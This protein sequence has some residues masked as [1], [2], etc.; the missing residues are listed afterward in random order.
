MLECKETSV[1]D[2][3]QQTKSCC[4][5]NKLIFCMTCLINCEW[6]SLVGFMFSCLQVRNGWSNRGAFAVT[7][8]YHKRAVFS[9]SMYSECVL[10]LCFIIQ[11]YLQGFFNHNF[12]VLGPGYPEAPLTAQTH[13]SHCFA[14]ET[15][16]STDFWSW[17]Q[18]MA[19]FFCLLSETQ[20]EK[21]GS[22]EWIFSIYLLL[23]TVPFYT[24]PRLP[25]W[26]DIWWKN[27]LNSKLS[28]HLYMQ[29]CGTLKK[30]VKPMSTEVKGCQA[31]FS[32]REMKQHMNVQRVERRLNLENSF[33]AE[34]LWHTTVF[35]YTTF[36]K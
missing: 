36:Q 16:F 17:L 9:N 21:H 3:R 4:I 26:M 24:A 12:S 23:L 18:K 13:A 28:L 25:K 22:I 30:E 34:T 27:R 31:S 2:V 1:C 35:K 8:F 29:V 7:S 15:W 32:L 6:V 19:H 11:S 33:S 14:L 5:T 10:C 20:D